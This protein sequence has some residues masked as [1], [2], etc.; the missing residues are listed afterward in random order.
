MSQN[1]GSMSFETYHPIATLLSVASTIARRIEMTDRLLTAVTLFALCGA[2]AAAVHIKV[3]R[4]QPATLE[5]HVRPLAPPE[6]G[7]IN[8]AFV[9]SDETEAMDL[10]GPW[11]VFEDV[12]LKNHQVRHSDGGKAS[13]F[14]PY[15][16]SDSLE[17]L[18]ANGLM[19]VPNYTFETAPKPR[20]IVIPA[21]KGRSAKQERWLVNNSKTADVTMSVCTGVSMLADYGMLDHQKATTHHQ[22]LEKFQE[23][24]PTVQFVTDT[25]YVEND[26]ISTAGGLTSGIDLALH[27]VE[28]Y[29]GPAIAQSTADYLEYHSGLWKQPRLGQTKMEAEIR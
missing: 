21:Q 28:R 10:A 7:Q 12:V 24:Y 9:I 13:P 2:I 1:A 22:Y 16:V 6:K 29:Y 26:K 15:T 20:V 25:R 5:S 23:Q 14:N 3:D 18:N 8:V 27:V 19:L 17:P 11:E 4:P